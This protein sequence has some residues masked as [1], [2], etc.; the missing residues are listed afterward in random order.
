MLKL[1]TDSSDLNIVAVGDSTADA[2]NEF[3]YLWFAWLATLY[4]AFTFEYYPPD[5]AGGYG[6]VVTIQTGSGSHKARLYN[7]SV[8]GTS[9]DYLMGSRFAGAFQTPGLSW[10]MVIWNHGKNLVSVNNQVVS[11]GMCLASIAQVQL[12]F[13]TAQHIVVDQY[14]NRDDASMT[15]IHAGWIDITTAAPGISLIDLFSGPYVS[16]DYTDNVHLTSAANSAKLLPKMQAWWNS[17]RAGAWTGE[18]AWLSTTVANMLDGASGEDYA[19]FALD[20][21]SGSVPGAAAAVP[22]GWSNNGTIAYSKEAVI[23][24]NG[25]ARSQKMQGSGAGQTRMFKGQV[26]G[27]INALKGNYATLTVIEYIGAGAASSVGRIDVTTNG[28]GAVSATSRASA[29]AQGAWKVSVLGP[30]LCPAD[31]TTCSVSLYHDTS[32]TPDAANPVYYQWACLSVG[33][34]PRAPS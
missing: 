13:P 34:L 32:A 2:S 26:A 27:N 22:F 29:N 24:Y 5:A 14:P 6:A 19:N 15:P 8:T 28:T 31:M 20:G 10:D 7:N 4:P 17:T 1:Q 9:P 23:T 21:T 11:E 18:G 25:A 30:I 33:K 16:G 12:A 3:L